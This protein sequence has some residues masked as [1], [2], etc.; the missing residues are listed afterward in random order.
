[1]KEDLWWSLPEHRRKRRH[2]K[3][4]TP[5]KPEIH[6]DLGIAN[7]PEIIADRVQFGH[8]ES[9]LML[10]RQTFGK[11]NVTSPVERVNRFTVLRMNTNKT[12]A[13]VMRRLAAVMRT[14]PHKARKSITF[15]TGS[16]FMDWPHLQAEVRTQ[17]WFAIQ[18]LRGKKDPSKTLT[19]AP[20]AECHARSIQRRS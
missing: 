7:R 10:F 18:A 3:A 6:P 13:R 11:A 4:R 17:T 1:M 2:R 19:D 16:E 20:G 15:G 5:K 9:D 14:L 8:W 12:T